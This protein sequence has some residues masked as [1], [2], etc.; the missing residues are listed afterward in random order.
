MGILHL[1]RAIYDAIRAHGEE[2]YPYECCG[3]LL[4]TIHANGTAGP[5]SPLSAPATPAPTPPTTATTSP[6]WSW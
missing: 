4:G 3:A 2:T 5:S 6:L 1:T